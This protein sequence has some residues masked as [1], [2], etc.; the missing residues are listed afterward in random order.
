MIS[1]IAQPSAGLAVIPEY[2]SDPPQLVATI[3]SDAGR[4]VRR[5]ASTRGS[6]CAISA[7]AA[8][9]AFRVPPSRWIVT[10]GGRP[11]GFPFGEPYGGDTESWTIGSA[12]L[13]SQPGLPTTV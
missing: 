7:T 10:T 2:P 8:S 11:L 5:A 13:T 6:S 1:S 3:R 12:W 9:T 4:G